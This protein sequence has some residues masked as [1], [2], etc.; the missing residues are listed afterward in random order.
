MQM[1]RH[2]IM[3]KWRPGVTQHQI[4]DWLA[5]CNRIPVECPQLYNWQCGPAIPG[6]NPDR[7]TTHD[8]CV[9]FDL[10]SPAEYAEYLRHPYPQSVREESFAL[11]EPEQIAGI[12]VMVEVP[13]AVR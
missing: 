9:S 13:A 3:L 4:D 7:P 10:R 11:I 1:I 5:K 2:I 12:N 6:P 8:F